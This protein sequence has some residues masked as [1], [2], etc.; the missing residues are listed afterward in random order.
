[1]EMYNL[2]LKLIII[3]DNLEKQDDAFRIET[4][5]N[6]NNKKSI[7]IFLPGINEIDEMY[8]KLVQLKNTGK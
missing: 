8:K 3:I 5:S 7:L 6:D 1:M 2:A 4:D